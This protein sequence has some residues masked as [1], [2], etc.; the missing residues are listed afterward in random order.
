[1]DIKELSIDLETYSDVDIKKGG[2]YKYAESPNFEILLFAVSINGGPVTVYDLACG[3]TPPDEIIDALVD[4]SV[5]KWAFNAVFERVCISYWLKKHYPAKFVSYS[6]PEDTVGNYLN[7]ESWRCTM[8]WS[9]YMGLPLSLEGVGAVLKLQDQK[10]K[11]GKDLIRFFCVPCKATKANGGRTRNLPHHAPDKW[12]LFKSYNKR[13]VEVEM[14][15]KQKLAAFPVLHIS[16]KRNPFHAL[17][18]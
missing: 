18:V 16:E 15:I 1:M 14:A 13:D 5:I 4:D 9:A 2:V 7:P 6:I 12:A 3:D 11:E 17:A 10:M 8:I